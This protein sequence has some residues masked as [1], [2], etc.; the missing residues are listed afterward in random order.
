MPRIDSAR[1]RISSLSQ[2]ESIVRYLVITLITL[3]IATT[4]FVEPSS[5]PMV[6]RMKFCCRA[7]RSKSPFSR[8]WRVRT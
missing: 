8:P 5:S 6:A 2:V 3:V 7:I 4:F 1:L